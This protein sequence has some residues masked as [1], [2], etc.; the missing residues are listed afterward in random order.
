MS[1]PRVKTRPGLRRNI[2]SSSNSLSAR[3]SCCLV[4]PRDPAGHA[5]TVVAVLEQHRQVV[6]A[7]GAGH[8]HHHRM[9][10]ALDQRRPL[11][12]RDWARTLLAT[13]IVFASDVLGSGVVRPIT[14][15]LDDVETL[16]SL[17]GLQIKLA[18]VIL[19]RGAWA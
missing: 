17:R 3:R 1:C 19:R 18:G 8:L 11:S 9:I 16:H 6:L 5:V 4:P 7:G 13:E 12:R 2:S 15:G 14:T 10:D